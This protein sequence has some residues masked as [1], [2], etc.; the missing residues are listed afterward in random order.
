MKAKFIKDMNNFRGEAKIYEVSPAISFG[1][2]ENTKFIIVSKIDNEFGQET[3]IFPANEDGEIK[4]YCELS[5][6]QKGDIS[7]GQVLRDA[8]YEICEA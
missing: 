4:D 6:S 7:H 2:N 3:Y 5:G 1:D 8:G